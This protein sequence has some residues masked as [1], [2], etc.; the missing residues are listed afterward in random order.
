M[1]NSPAYIYGKNAVIE[2]LNSGADLAKIF[3]V[4]GLQGSS[5]HS[6]YSRA[7]KEKIPCVI[8]DK[9]KFAELE[10]LYC[11]P[12][13][14]SQGVMALRNLVD[15]ISVRELI[16]LSKEKKNPIIVIL[17]EITD[18]QNLGAIARSAECAGAAGIIVPERRSAPVTP[19]AIKTSAGALEYIPVATAGNLTQ[20]IDILKDSGFWVVGTDASGKNEHT[21]AIYDRPIALVIGSEGKGIRHLVAKSCDYL[22]KI[23][24][25]GKISS[26]NASV[27]AGVVLFEIIRQRQL[28]EKAE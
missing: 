9:H 28:A 14:K 17:D 3:I 12:G 4:H 11:P 13:A 19:V 5:V 22:V 26:L 21:D 27:S 23:P 8:C 6:V 7:K 24:L 15:T 20:A 25:L 10:K 18:P 16:K 1:N 2:A